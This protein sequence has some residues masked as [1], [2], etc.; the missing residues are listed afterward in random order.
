MCACQVKVYR[1]H[2]WKCDGPCQR[3]PPFYGLVKRATNRAPSPWDPWWPKHQESCGGV[4][5]KIKEPEGYGE[6]KGKGRDG[7]D[8]G[9]GKEKGKAGS[10][11]IRDLLK[12][13]G[14]ESGGTGSRFDSFKGRGHTVGGTGSQGGSSSDEDLRSKMLAAAERRRQENVKLRLACRARN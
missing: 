14:E 4:F 6:K 1:Q 13:K 12:R 2:W 7:G 10:K 3:R 5:R 11:D 9:K 8:G